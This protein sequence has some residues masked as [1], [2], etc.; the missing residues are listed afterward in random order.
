LLLPGLWT[1]GCTGGAFSTD[2]GAAGSAA[3]GGGDNDYGEAGSGTGAV[4]CGGPEDCDDG[5]SCTTDLCNADGTCNTSPKCAGAQKCCE[6]DCAECCDD[7]DCDDGVSCTVNTCFSGQ[8][9]YVPEDS[10]CDA[11]QYCSAKDGCRARAACGILVDADPLAECDDQN[12]CTTDICADNFCRHDFCGKGAADPTLTMCCEGTGC[13]KDCCNDAQ[14]DTDNDPCT[15]GSCKEG[16]CSLAPLCAK[17]QQCCPGAD[18]RTATC[19]SCC[20]AAECDDR[21]SC[22]E[23]ACG[24]GQCSHTPTTKK[25]TAGEVCNALKG[26]QKADICKDSSDCHP[27]N[28]CQLNPTCEDGSCHFDSCGA[29]T[30][31]CV[32][33]GSA[34]STSTC[35]AC[36]DASECS[37]NIACTNDSC[38]PS[39]CNH[40]PVDANCPI[41]GQRC[42][43]ALGCVGCLKDADCGD[44]LDCTTDSCVRNTCTHVNTCGK[45]QYCTRYGCSTCVSDSDC[46][47]AIVNQDAALP[48]GCATSTCV[49]GQCQTAAKDCG[50]FQICC[51]PY[52]CQLH[53]GIETQ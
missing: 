40:E 39:G 32:S 35:A 45:Y 43:P 6:G 34:T 37:D 50:D 36:C 26:C 4:K 16:K 27:T 12:G 8:C 19:G 31:C 38:G 42:D 46:Q 15:V 2:G 41:E 49:K 21:V 44:G 11:T 28:G 18:G 53:C 47:G 1:S 14:C 3:A 17:G 7:A 29:G 48:A 25:C 5:V 23:D 9:M 20:S 24:G 30:K 13:A 10:A 22:T 33:A 51:P 52:G